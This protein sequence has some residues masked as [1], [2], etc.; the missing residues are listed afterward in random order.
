LKPASFGWNRAG[1]KLRPCKFSGD[2]I[3]VRKLSRNFRARQN[4]K[5]KDG[6]QSLPH[7]PKLLPL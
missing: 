4:T 2:R 3:N 5:Y 6:A 1:I 7:P